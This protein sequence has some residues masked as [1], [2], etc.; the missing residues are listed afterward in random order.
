VWSLRDYTHIHIHIVSIGRKKKRPVLTERSQGFSGDRHG[1][2][3]RKHGKSLYMYVQALKK[4]REGILKCMTY[5]CECYVWNTD[6]S[7]YY[8]HPISNPVEARHTR[9]CILDQRKSMA[10]NK[11]PIVNECGHFDEKYVQMLKCRYP[12]CTFLNV[13][14][15]TL[16]LPDF[17]S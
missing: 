12:G 16:V 14:L 1:A 10:H 15:Q 9:K 8:V 11:A 2:K 13:G 5:V 4:D 3:K 17:I 7:A 6:D